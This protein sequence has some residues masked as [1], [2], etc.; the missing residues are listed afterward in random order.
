M[1]S[2]GE[3]DGVVAGLNTKLRKFKEEWG[4]ECL[5]RVRA[6]TPVLTGALKSGW[7]F[8]MKATD[9]EIYN[10]MD[11]AAYVEYGTPKMAPRAMLGTTLLEADQITDVAKKKAGL[12]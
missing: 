5:E 12:K 2:N 8:D 6:R 1:T 3:I 11:Y 9:I 4:V 7:G 10:T